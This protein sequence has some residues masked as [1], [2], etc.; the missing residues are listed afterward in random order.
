[1]KIFALLDYNEACY[2]LN[3]NNDDF[4]NFLTFGY[5]CK[6]LILKLQK[7]LS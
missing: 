5:H 6:K 4:L 7:Y 3:Y 2:K 1:M